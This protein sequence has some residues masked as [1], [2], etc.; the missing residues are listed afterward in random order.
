MCPI[1]D[2]GWQVGNM[3]TTQD[4]TTEDLRQELGAALAQK[5][6]LAEELATRTAELLERKTE[7]DERIGYQAA[8]NDGLKAMSA[9]PGD[10]QP[11][12]DLIAERAR[13]I[14]DAYGATV[15]EFDGT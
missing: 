10:P 8:T 6:A 3:S 4:K 11:V 5:A 12:F 1:N 15:F 9:S 2:L 13:D 7:S 14:C